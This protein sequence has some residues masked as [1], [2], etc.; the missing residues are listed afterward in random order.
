[1]SWNTFLLTSTALYAA[2]YTGLVLFELYGRRKGS[3]E[4]PDTVTSYTLPVSPGP[5]PGEHDR[6]E[7]H[8]S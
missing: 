1:M 6:Q 8:S 3:E 7:E 2:Y 4:A 5:D